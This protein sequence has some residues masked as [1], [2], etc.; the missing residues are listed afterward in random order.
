MF[1]PVCPRSALSQLN[2]IWVR[3]TSVDGEIAVIDSL[4]ANYRRYRKKESKK[5]IE[6][7]IHRDNSER[8][9]FEELSFGRKFF[10]A[11]LADLFEQVPNQSRLER[12]DD[13]VAV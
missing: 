12:I 11:L 6:S 9:C 2:C 3:K 4:G 7:W 5:K 8:L 13:L 1:R 10:T